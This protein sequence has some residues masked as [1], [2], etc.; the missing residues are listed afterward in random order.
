MKVYVC[1][2]DHGYMKKGMLFAFDEEPDLHYW[3]EFSLDL[4][5]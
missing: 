3:E 4:K 1:R 2:R 5:R